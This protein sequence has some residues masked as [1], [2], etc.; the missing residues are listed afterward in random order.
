M[1]RAVALATLLCVTP[2]FAEGETPAAARFH[3][4]VEWPRK[5]LLISGLCVFGSSY[6]NYVFLLLARN[7][8]QAS[9][10]GALIFIPAAGPLFTYYDDSSFFWGFFALGVVQLAGL[11]L[12]TLAFALGPSHQVVDRKQDDELSFFIAPGVGKNPLGV[13]FNLSGW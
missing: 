12:T 9:H 5:G 1:R 10:N 3:E 13:T 2:V 11:V 4:E 8:V 7:D 6:L